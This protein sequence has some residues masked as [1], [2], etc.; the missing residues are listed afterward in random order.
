MANGSQPDCDDD[1]M[2]CPAV[3]QDSATPDIWNPLPGFETVRA[4]G[5]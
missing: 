5:S 2:F 3:H 1:G 4:D